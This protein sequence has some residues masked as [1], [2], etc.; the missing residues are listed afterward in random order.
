LC[1][2]HLQRH[3]RLSQL[4]Q[5]LLAS[6]QLPP[7]RL[8]L[9][10]LL[11]RLLGL[12]P[13]GRQFCARPVQ[14]LRRGPSRLLLCCQGVARCGELLRLLGRLLARGCQVGVRLLELR[15]GCLALQLLRPGAALCCLQLLLQLEH[16]HACG[17]GV[18]G[19]CGW[20][21]GWRGVAPWGVLR[22]DAARSS[23]AAARLPPACGTALQQP[24]PAASSHAAHLT[25]ELLG[26]KGGLVPLLERGVGTGLEEGELSRRRCSRGLEIGFRRPARLGLPAQLGCTGGHVLSQCLPLALQRLGARGGGAGGGGGGAGW[27]HGWTGIDVHA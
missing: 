2:P 16:L 23:A 12:L 4:L 27:V 9:R 19:G 14:L 11:R 22:G 13:G 17:A 1:T 24:T 26:G 7:Q 5:R 25:P 21:G 15:G 6:L 18:F 8:Q 20:V 3:V 10:Q